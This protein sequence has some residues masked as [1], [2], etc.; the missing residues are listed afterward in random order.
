MTTL[1]V[2]DAVRVLRGR[3]IGYCGTVVRVLA[4]GDPPRAR[5]AF[6]MRRGPHEEWFALDDLDRGRS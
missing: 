1:E 4:D 3:M 5:V 6:K 2:G